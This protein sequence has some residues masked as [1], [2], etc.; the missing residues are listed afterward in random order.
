MTTCFFGCGKRFV[1]DFYTFDA[2]SDT[3]AY[4]ILSQKYDKSSGQVTLALKWDEASK[5]WVSVWDHHLVE[6]IKGGRRG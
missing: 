2:S 1:G 6:K 5:R 4:E 3:E